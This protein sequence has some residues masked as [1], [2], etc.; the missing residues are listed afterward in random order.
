[1]FFTEN[2]DVD[3][4]DEKLLFGQ[5]MFEISNIFCSVCIVMSDSMVKMLFEC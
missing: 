4:N 3:L 2:C 5:G 1:M